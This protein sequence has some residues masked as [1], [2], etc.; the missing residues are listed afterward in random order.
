MDIVPIIGSGSL[1]TMVE[2]TR[3]G[4]N[5][6]WGNFKAEGIV[7]RP[8]VELKARDGS[9]IITKIKYKDF[10]HDRLTD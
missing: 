6:I 3:A 7:A 8:A 5:S 4:F 1:K 10:A 2:M 9:R